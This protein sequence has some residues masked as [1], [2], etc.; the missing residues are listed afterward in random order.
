[1]QVSNP[2]L[3]LLPFRLP[4]LSPTLQHHHELQSFSP[5]PTATS[6]DLLSRWDLC[7]SLW[8]DCRGWGSEIGDR[9]CESA[10][11][12]GFS[13]HYSISPPR[14]WRSDIGDHFALP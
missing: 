3:S 11:S 12:G 4:S 9:D 6:C 14:G 5:P 1:M 13:S 10:L 2:L 8:M 7:F